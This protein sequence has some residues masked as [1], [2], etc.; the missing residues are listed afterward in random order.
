M[1]KVVRGKPTPEELAAVV[2]VLTVAG[3]PAAPPAPARPTSAWA[4]RRLPLRTAHS[5]GPTGWLA[6]ALPR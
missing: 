6:P 2:S 4:S 3:T 5:W 1:I